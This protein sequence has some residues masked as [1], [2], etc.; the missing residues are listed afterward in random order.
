MIN[1]VDPR[2]LLDPVLNAP[3][4]VCNVTCSRHFMLKLTLAF[5]KRLKLTPMIHP[6]LDMSIFPV[7]GRIISHWYLACGILPVCISLITMVLGPGVPIPASIIVDS[8]TDYV[9]D[10]ERTTI[11]AA[12]DS[13]EP[14]SFDVQ[15]SLNNIILSRFG[16]RQIPTQC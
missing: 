14:F 13:N 1:P 11:K 6:G 8:F 10:A 9:S 3:E 4:K 5:L 15:A 7:L 16:R 2:S 12:L